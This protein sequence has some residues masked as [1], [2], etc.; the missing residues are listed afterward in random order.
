[1]GEV[2][3]YGTG[4]IRIRDWLKS[5]PKLSYQVISKEDFTKVSLVEDDKLGDKLGD[6]QK[7][8]IDIIAKQP[9]VSQSE[10]SKQ[11]NISQTAVENNIKKLKQF[12][13]LKRIGPAKSGHWEILK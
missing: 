1:M 6:N 7:R 4:F 12:G 13:I 3:K 9:Q 10:I 11:L 8:I 2:E 5:Y